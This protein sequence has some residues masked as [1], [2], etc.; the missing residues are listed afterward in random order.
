MSRSTGYFLCW[1]CFHPLGF[2]TQPWTS[3][4]LAPLNQNSS[5]SLSAFPLSS[6]SVKWVICSAFP[7]KVNGTS[8]FDSSSS[9][10]WRLRIINTSLGEVSEDWVNNNLPVKRAWIPDAA[11]LPTR[12]TGV[13]YFDDS[14]GFVEDSLG[15]GGIGN[16]NIL[17]LASSPAVKYMK[18][19]SLE[20]WWRVS[21]KH[22]RQGLQF[23][24]L[25]HL[26]ND[27]NPVS[28]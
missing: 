20:N 19:P 1:L 5:P 8:L 18:F 26:E 25:M 28:T 4:S 7:S 2:K 23:S 24:P 12:T 16:T 6:A 3:L 14:L 22:L 10:R 11:L 13:R 15:V 17:T 27:P 9:K 21:Y